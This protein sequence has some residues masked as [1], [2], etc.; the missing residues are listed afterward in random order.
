MTV[1]IGRL[2]ER[3][4]TGLIELGRAPEA[5]RRRVAL[6]RVR[7]HGLRALERE[8]EAARRI[9]VR[10]DGRH[11]VKTSGAPWH[12]E[13]AVAHP[14]ASSRLRRARRPG[15]F[16]AEAGVEGPGARRRAF[17]CAPPCATLSL[18]PG[19]DRADTCR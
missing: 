19:A 10:S 9:D 14:R 8:V 15:A 16:G 18:A 17:Q 4:N 6:D 13:V 1:P 2:L 5:G 7:V 3:R 11:H 12:A